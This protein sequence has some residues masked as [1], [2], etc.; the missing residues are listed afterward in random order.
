MRDS[1]R[2]DYIDR[3]CVCEK[4]QVGVFLLNNQLPN[5]QR[6]LCDQCY[7]IFKGH[8]ISI[9]YE[10]A[11]REMN[12]KKEQK[13][14]FRKIIIEQQ[15][16]PIEKLLQLLN[17]YKQDI[18]YE[19][20][21]IVLCV[22]EWIRII[23]KIKDVQNKSNSF[24][25]I[26]SLRCP[27][28]IKDQNETLQF[29][30]SIK[31]CNLQFCYK[32]L[33]KIQNFT[34]I[35]KL[36]EGYQYIL[37]SLFQIEPK[38]ETSTSELLNSLKNTLCIFHQQ[39]ITKV[40]YQDSSNSFLTLCIQCQNKTGESLEIFCD[41]WS[42]F[43]KNK[44]KSYKKLNQFL[45][46]K[47]QQQNNI[48]INN[49]RK[50]NCQFNQAIFN[51]FQQGANIL[52]QQCNQ[53][54]D[55]KNAELNLKIFNMIASMVSNADQN[56]LFTVKSNQINKNITDNNPIKLIDNILR[57]Q[58]QNNLIFS[59][60]RYNQDYIIQDLTR[61]GPIQYKPLS[62]QNESCNALAF[63]PSK[64]LMITNQG[65]KI[66]IYQLNNV[67]WERIKQIE[68]LNN[69]LSVTCIIHSKFYNSFVTADEKLAIWKYSDNIDI[70]QQQDFH[71]QNG[72]I[73]CLII[74]K[75]ETQLLSGGKEIQV[76]QLNFDTSQLKYEYSLFEHEGRILSLSLNDSEMYLVSYCEN[77]MIIVRQKTEEKWTLMQIVNS[78]IKECRDKKYKQNQFFFK[79]DNDFY[80]QTQEQLLLDHQYE[81]ARKNLDQSGFPIIQVH[82]HN[83][84]LI[85]IRNNI[86]T[87]RQQLDGTYAI[88]QNCMEFQSSSIFGNILYIPEKDQYYLIIWDQSLK[89]Y[90]IVF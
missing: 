88:L 61:Y 49:Q 72:Y 63:N 66:N 46:D 13:D 9:R 77:K 83:L 32:L 67:I 89:T 57:Q 84:I 8:E 52:Q 74:N 10:N 43:L 18:I 28:S 6:L 4:N 86:Y 56:N 14:N 45:R 50:I 51:L 70:C 16:K 1:M 76:Y 35:S 69:E 34:N 81:D 24:D 53:I 29:K 30:H 38:I 21:S 78:T 60:Q 47:I 85:K 33:H 5:N 41:K 2:E 79:I 3:K 36:Q 44:E 68:K 31:Q 23:S 20:N 40:F 80:E 59:N 37:E 58:V 17:S 55:L 12:E 82:D 54:E 48:Q 73:N 71:K 19:I 11:L 22:N 26:Y 42:I 64:L 65:N 87:M 90:Q 62:Y 25:E 27:N 15:I 75:K 39:P 7:Q